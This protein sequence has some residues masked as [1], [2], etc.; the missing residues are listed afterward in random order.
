MIPALLIFAVTST[1]PLSATEAQA[2]RDLEMCIGALRHD[3]VNEE[4]I[5]ADFEAEREIRAAD[6]IRLTDGAPEPERS[7]WDDALPMVLPVV[8]AA[9]GAASG[10]LACSLADCATLPH[11]GVA[12]AGAA[13]GAVLGNVISP[14]R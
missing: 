4:S 6:E 2:Y 14:S 10:S 13:L 9:A 8:V 3:D 11:A 5:R 1:T 7:W 12:A